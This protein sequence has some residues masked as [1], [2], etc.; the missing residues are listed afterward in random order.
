MAKLPNLVTNSLE[1]E[2]INYAYTDAG[3]IRCSFLLKYQVEQDVKNFKIKLKIQLFVKMDY[4]NSSEYNGIYWDDIYIGTR[5]TS[6]NLIYFDLK[7]E[8][9]DC[10]LRIN[11]SKGIT[12]NG[13]TISS[14]AMVYN[15]IHEAELTLDCPENGTL[16][17]PIW[18]GRKA[19]SGSRDFFSDYTIIKLRLPRFSSMAYKINNK[20]I[21]VMPW[22]KVDGEWKRALQYIKVD[23][24]W[25]KYNNIYPAR[26]W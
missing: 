12:V 22:I 21:N 19:S 11:S 26:D 23:G 18:C 15:K 25:K 17:L 7:N 2:A 1:G 4:D 10:A 24:V 20:Y 3:R 8:E 13:K 6:N 14:N 16:G 5:D 9:S